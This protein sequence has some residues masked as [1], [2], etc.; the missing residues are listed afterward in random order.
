M[1]ISIF[2]LIVWDSPYSRSTVLIQHTG[3]L[4][5]CTEICQVLSLTVTSKSNY[6][7]IVKIRKY[8][9]IYPRSGSIIRLFILRVQLRHEKTPI[10]ETKVH[11]EFY[12]WYLRIVILTYIYNVYHTLYSNDQGAAIRIGFILNACILYIGELCKY[13]ILN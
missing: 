8:F 5:E 9:Q 10:I 3:P 6:S 11:S 12:C 2:C 13:T 1:Y 7:P 4:L